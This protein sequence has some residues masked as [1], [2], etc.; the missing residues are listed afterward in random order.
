MDYQGGGGFGGGGGGGGYGGGGGGGFQQSQGGQD[1]SGGGQRRRS[2]DEQTCIPVTIRMILSARQQAGGGDDGAEAL[3]LEDGRKLCHVRIV[4]A[5][6]TFSELSTNVLYQIEDGTGLIDVKQWID[7]NA[8]TALAELRQQTMKDN[9]YVKIVGSVKDYDGGKQILADSI[10]PISTG[11]EISH[12]MLEV[13]YTGESHKRRTSYVSAP[14]AGFAGS[15]A[16]GGGVG[17]GGGVPP[18]MGRPLGVGGGNNNQQGPVE[19]SMREAVMSFVRNASN[20]AEEGG[21]IAVCIQHLT[22]GGKYSEAEI[23]KCFEDLTAEGHIYSTCDEET[24]KL[25]L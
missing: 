7:E 13:V 9:I 2:Y 18:Q 16:V 20:E 6:R 11:N 10:R 4:G 5:V 25:A 24:F 22:A 12:H 14:Q 23:R 1:G 17:F 15:N 19:D 8:C 3:H 21:N